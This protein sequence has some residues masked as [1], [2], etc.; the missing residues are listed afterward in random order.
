MKIAGRVEEERVAGNIAVRPGHARAAPRK[1]CAAGAESIIILESLGC[2][3]VSSVA[4]K[5][6]LTGS[7]DDNV[8]EQLRLRVGASSID[9][10][11]PRALVA[12]DGVVDKGRSRV[13]FR[14]REIN[15]AARPAGTVVDD[16]VLDDHCVVVRGCDP[17]PLEECDPAPCVAGSVVA[18]DVVLDRRGSGIDKANAPAVGA[19]PR[20]SANRVS[21]DLNRAFP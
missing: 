4:I 17:A 5:S 18:D 13:V 3:T 8:V 1:A 15:S 9:T 16:E 19:A 21:D 20:I 12:S 10:R 2:L 6:R 7:G 14:H 11:G